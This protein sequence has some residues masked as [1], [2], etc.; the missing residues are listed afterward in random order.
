MTDRACSVVQRKNAREM[1]VCGMIC[2][3]CCCCCTAPYA[4]GPYLSV[5]AMPVPSLTQSVYASE[6]AS[7]FYTLAPIGGG[8][9]AEKQTC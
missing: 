6:C 5:C 9:W 3:F 4:C 7:A 8:L 2:I 1:E